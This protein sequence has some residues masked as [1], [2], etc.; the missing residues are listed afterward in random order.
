MKKITFLLLLC[1]V[2][3]SYGQTQLLS[4]VDEIDNGG[5]FVNST[6]FNYEYD[7]NGNLETETIFF[8]NTS[9]WEAFGKTMYTYNANSKATEEIFQSFNMANNMFE[10]SE[11]IVYTYGINGNIEKIE[12]Y[13][14]ETGAWVAES[15]TNITYTNGLL[16]AGITE[17]LEGG[18]W[19]N[20]FRSTI[21][22]NPNSTRSQIVDDIWNTS[23]S[24]WELDERSLFSYDANNKISLVETET[25]NGS[26]WEADYNIF[27]ALDSNGNRISETETFGGGSPT[28][29]TYTYDTSALMSS[30]ANPFADYNDLE[31]IF[32]D[33]PY[34]NK[35]LS[36]TSG[37][38]NRTTFDYNNV[39][40]VD[41]VSRLKKMNVRI[42][43]N[44][45]Q[46]FI[47]ITSSENIEKIEVYNTLGSKVM[48][49]SLKEIDI[50]DL[51]NGLYLV[52]ISLDN[53]S[54]VVKKL[55]KE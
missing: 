37:S 53:G 18:I 55:V 1:F 49:A 12:D 28:T 21:T 34:V 8:W 38:S 43:P 7:S 5:T 36:I 35:V 41:D 29:E 2:I 4:R 27:Y 13:V 46:D 3:Q 11:R 40:S 9:T 20:S 39:L 17:D 19:V 25:R 14:W 44:P 47:T 10:N 52:S 33:F 54:K 15:R 31:Y 16:T 6:G 45:S 51:S 26:V 42:F 23:S 32:E 30:F 50:R 24:V 48:T 22:Y